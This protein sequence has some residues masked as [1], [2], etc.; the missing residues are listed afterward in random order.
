MT[1]STSLFIVSLMIGIIC[2]SAFFSWLGWSKKGS[3]SAG[4]RQISI[5]HG[6]PVSHPVHL[7]LEELKRKA[8]E[9]SGGKLQFSV[10]PAAQLGSESQC[11]EKAQLGTLDITKVSAAP[12]SNFV[13]VFKIFS[14]PYLFQ[15]EDQY[16]KVLEGEIGQEMLDALSVRGD[17]SPSGLH[18][19]GYFDSGSRSFYSVDPVKSVDDMRGKKFRVMNDPVA[20]DMVQAMGGSPTPIDFGEL[21]TALKQGAVDGAENN[22]PSFLTSGHHEVC[23]HY[24]L[25]H[26]SRVPDVIIISS[27][28]WDQLNPQERE[29]LELA[30]THAEKFQREL[31]KAENERSLEALRKHGV[32]ITE[33]DLTPFRDV[34]KSVYNKHSTATFRALVQ[35]IQSTH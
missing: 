20:M 25:N 12:I 6:L 21:Y 33:P 19:L 8:E 29:W 9:L 27:K 2:T 3:V 16:W 31:W 34:S 10:F 24:L 23:K 15:D 11:L 17:G 4:S 7:G 22:A 14:L 32:V 18:G 13:P 1:R 26:H 5:A 35:R 28:L 30:I